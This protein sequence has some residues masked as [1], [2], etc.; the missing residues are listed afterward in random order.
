M[1]LKEKHLLVITS[2]KPL[3]LAMILET[4][5]N[6]A[7]SGKEVRYV[8]LT[9][10][11]LKIFEFP[12]AD[13]LNSNIYKTRIKRIEQKLNTI[14][15]KRII[16]STEPSIKK[17]IS[18]DQKL[19]R[20]AAKNEI[21]SLKR[22]SNPCLKCY[23]NLYFALINLYNYSY[24]YLESILK[25]NSFS[26]V[27]I[28]NG[29]FIVGN[30][31]W[32]LCNQFDIKIKFLEQA[33]MSFSDRYWLFHKPVHSPAY[34]AKIVSEFYSSSTNLQKRNVEKYAHEWFSARI[35]GLSQNF[36]AN[37]NID[38][39]K[40]NNRVNII[41]YFHSSED[42]LILSNLKEVSWGS[43]FEIIDNLCEIIQSKSGYKLLIRIHPNLKFKSNKEI[44]MW[45]IYLKELKQK[46]RN[47]DYFWFDSPVNTY[48]L[49]KSSRIVFTS[50]STIGPES[51]FMGKPNVLCGNSLYSKMQMSYKPKNPRELV[52][53]FDSYIR[54]A[55]KSKFIE[56]AKKFG[57]FQFLG[58]FQYKYITI[59]STA[60][61]INF[62]GIKLNHSLLYSA[63]IRLDKLNHRFFGSKGSC[64]KC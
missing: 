33:N 62:D 7:S 32:N 57:Y 12:I 55:K 20:A 51:A 3:E 16:N 21:I 45:D 58:G 36:T 11:P 1:S 10:G 35:S 34:R 42:E 25:L 49:I 47:V 6:L 2:N 59:N 15:I 50:G 5:M 8:D 13:R 64:Y 14:G 30:A 19:S 63:L 40:V 17:R 44:Q 24:L 28:Y 60:T 56:N 29:R 31:V 52:K 48:S 9:S 38:Y 54:H 27:Y 43:Q 26:N 46:Y 39:K 61:R 22:E 23:K 41:S 53:N 37:Q 4:G 18:I